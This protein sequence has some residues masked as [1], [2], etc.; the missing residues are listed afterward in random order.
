L[1]SLIGGAIPGSGTGSLVITSFGNGATGD[2]QVNFDGTTPVGLVD[3]DV[4]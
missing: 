1:C 2:Y 3:F 4:N